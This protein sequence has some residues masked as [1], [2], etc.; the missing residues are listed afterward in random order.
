M[1]NTI[2][3]AIDGIIDWAI[4]I[5]ALAVCLLHDTWILIRGSPKPTY[6]WRPQTLDD[7]LL[8]HKM[9]P[10]GDYPP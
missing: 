2:I 5:V 3:C 9:R 10:Y 6:D 7:R 4:I 1:K 8:R